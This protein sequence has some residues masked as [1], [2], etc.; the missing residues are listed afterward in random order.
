MD[1][2]RKATVTVTVEG[3]VVQHVEVPTGVRVV[4]KDYDIDGSESD[5]AE[6]TNGDNYVESVW[7]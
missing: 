6:D 7:E 2:E 1:Q 4:V 3:G 5:L